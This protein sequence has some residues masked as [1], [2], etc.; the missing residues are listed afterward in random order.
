MQKSPSA[1]GEVSRLLLALDELTNE[2]AMLLD[3]GHYW[4]ALAL[5]HRIE[6]LIGRLCSLGSEPPSAA[7]RSRADAILARRNESA[8]QLRNR[9]KRT[10][11]ERD[12]LAAGRR[13][14][15]SVA[16]AYGCRPRAARFEA[17][18]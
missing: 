2:E 9:M 16:P 1:S 13:R 5:G 3:A 14:L 12:R 15:E 10:L 4:D 11:A 7:A 18:V 6:P 8:E 17:S